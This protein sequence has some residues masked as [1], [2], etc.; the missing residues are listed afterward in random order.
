MEKA[1]QISCSKDHRRAYLRL[2]GYVLK[3]KAVSKTICLAELVPNYKG[4]MINIDFDE[5][6]RATG[7]EVLVLEKD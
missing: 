3:P 1:I 7:I 6:G 4:P 2:P 5:T